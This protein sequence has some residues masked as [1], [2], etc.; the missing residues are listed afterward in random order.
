MR[1]LG[2][3]VSVN[4]DS[5]VL[6]PAIC[7]GTFHF[8]VI[9]VTPNSHTSKVKCWLFSQPSEINFAKITQVLQ[10]SAD[11]TGR[12]GGRDGDVRA[13]SPGSLEVKERQQMRHPPQTQ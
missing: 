7:E 10:V 11:R 12:E 13:R 1:V 3:V 8:L 2:G 4:C 5:P 6:F 9:S